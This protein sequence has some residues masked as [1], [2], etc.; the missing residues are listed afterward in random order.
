MSG[1]ARMPSWYLNTYT[2]LVATPHGRQAALAKGLSPFI[3][4][5]IRRE[6]DLE[7]PLPAISCLCRGGRFAPR[8]VAGDVVGYMTKKDQYGHH[9]RHRRLAA[10]LRVRL[11]FPEHEEAAKWYRIRTKQL[12]SNCMVPNNPP[13]R[14][15]ES[16][17]SHRCATLT[18]GLLR[19][20][21]DRE[22]LKRV[23]LHPTIAI[24]D[25]LYVNVSWTAPMVEDALLI[26]AFGKVPSTQ[27]PGRLTDTN[28]RRF[29]DLIGL[30]APLSVP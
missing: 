30:D 26:E 19:Q 29:I 24:C 15:D 28:F 11:V 17:R 12:P 23:R 6:P 22:Y 18:D 27:N 13:K 2:P 1:D 9:K 7:H 20:V 25:R 4:G 3:D 21:W 14:I 10:I 5:S 16:H 8:L